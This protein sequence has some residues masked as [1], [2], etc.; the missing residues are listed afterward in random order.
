MLNRIDLSGLHIINI[1]DNKKAH[2]TLML[3][4]LYAI[5]AEVLFIT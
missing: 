5:N 4:G 2:L 1:D 3:N